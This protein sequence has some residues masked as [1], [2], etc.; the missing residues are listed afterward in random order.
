MAQDKGKTPIS[1]DLNLDSDPAYIMIENGKAQQQ[2][3]DCL[4]NDYKSTLPD[5]IHT[6]F[7]GNDI[8]ILIQMWDSWDSAYQKRFTDKFGHI[9]SLLK[10]KVDH[11]L[12]RAMLQF[13][14]PS[15][16]CFVLNEVDLVPTHEEYAEIIG[17]K[18]EYRGKVFWKNESS[19]IP[20]KLR[21]MDIPI[22]E[23]CGHET[24]Q[25]RERYE[26]TTFTSFLIKYPR[27]EGALNAFA[28]LIYGLVIFPKNL[29]YIDPS[30]ID[31]VG[32]VA[33]KGDPSTAILAETLMA[34]NYCRR[35]RKKA[36]FG[37]CTQL[38]YMWM[39]SHLSCLKYTEWFLV[40]DHIAE[41][42]K[43]IVD[44]K[45][46]G[47]WIKLFK[48]FTC[49][50]VIWR[51]TWMKREKV[52]YQSKMEPWLPLIGIWGVISYLPLLVRRQ[53]GSEQFIPLTQGL[54]CVEFL[55][56][57]LNEIKIAKAF[58]K[59]WK[60]KKEVKEGEESESATAGYM[61][62]H[63]RRIKD[64]VLPPEPNPSY[65]L[66]NDGKDTLAELTIEIQR[67]KDDTGLSE[68]SKKYQDEKAKGERDKRLYDEEIQ[69]LKQSLEWEGDVVKARDETI[70][71]L[72]KLYGEKRREAA[73]SS[74]KLEAQRYENGRLRKRLL[75][76]KQWCAELSHEV[77]ELKKKNVSS[78]PQSKQED[79]MKIQ[80]LEKAVA[81]LS[82]QLNV[83]KQVIQVHVGDIKELEQAKKGLVEAIEILKKE[84]E[85]WRRAYLV[86][87]NHVG[88]L[89]DKLEIGAQQA[90]HMK[91]KAQKI[92][93]KMIEEKMKP[94]GPQGQQVISNFLAMATQQYRQVLKLFN[95]VNYEM[96]R[97]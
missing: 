3:G 5:Q 48:N 46:K 17:V 67:L 83:Y 51:A 38:L 49:N 90:E 57:G 21:L 47:E 94:S 32:H 42:A 80:G 19:N 36:R 24:N 34:L 91:E 64:V 81:D 92:Q 52:K 65:P 6:T 58:A 88:Y 75:E 14:D 89:L 7:E 56:E 96:R 33:H 31:L 26:I 10:I 13:W 72:N 15:Y 87:L 84:Q 39:I 97:V 79:L 28:I 61:E 22:E 95:L 69:F 59:V 66:G 71:K 45:S 30:V 93:L 53:Y 16:R 70:K 63:Q 44:R 82:H 77:Q 60:Q 11:Q 78:A 8:S 12:I 18:C 50:D 37:G 29:G 40:E 20:K 74:R 68:L 23:L 62:W 27:S 73:S 25:G 35:S 2:F 86:K 55:Y 54:N 41:F 1:E 76:E 9:A 4:D 85:G 43:S